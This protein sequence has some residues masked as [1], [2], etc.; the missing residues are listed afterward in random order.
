MHAC[1]Q[2]CRALCANQNKYESQGL[3]SRRV[4]SLI[5]SRRVPSLIHSRRVPSL[6]H[7]RGVRS[8]IHSRGVRSLIHSRRVRS[9][10]HSRGVRSLIHSRSTF[11]DSFPGSDKLRRVLSIFQ[12][13]VRATEIIVWTSLLCLANSLTEFVGDFDNGE[14]T[15]KRILSAWPGIV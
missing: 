13:Q 8:L 6:I 7:S 5:H 3:H 10:I 4:R 15:F 9:L 14:S 1:C 12:R 2:K 11:P